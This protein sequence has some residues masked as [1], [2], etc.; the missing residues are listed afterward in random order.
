MDLHVFLKPIGSISI[1]IVIVN[2]TKVTIQSWI[3]MLKIIIPINY[4]AMYLDN[5]GPVNHLP[6]F[7]SLRYSHF[8]WVKCHDTSFIYHDTETSSN[9]SFTGKT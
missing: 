6:L 9:V 5:N 3:L 4:S 7:V 1:K 2:L 8:I